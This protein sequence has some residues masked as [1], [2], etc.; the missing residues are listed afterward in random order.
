VREVLEDHRLGTF[1]AFDRGNLMHW[2]HMRLNRLAAVKNVIRV[3]QLLVW[4]RGPG[5]SANRKGA[6]DGWWSH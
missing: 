6:D 4:T 5:R 2:A 3:L 1:D